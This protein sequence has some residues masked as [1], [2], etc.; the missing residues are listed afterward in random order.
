VLWEL[1][2]GSD[3]LARNAPEALVF[4]KAPVLPVRGC[5]FT[6]GADRDS[7]AAVF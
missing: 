3:D 7:D 6:D 4:M 5:C 1:C 2:E